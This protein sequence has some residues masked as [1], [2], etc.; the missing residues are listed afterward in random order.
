MA[1]ILVLGAGLNGLMT[2]MLLA[3]DG[4]AVTV[5]ERDQAPPPDDPEA[6]WEAW[7]RRGVNQFRMLHLMLPRWRALMAAELPE[8]LDELE[9][10]GGLRVNLV[11]SRRDERTGGARDG[12]DIFETMTAR[13]PVIESAVA[14]VA[15][16]T[17]GVRLRRGVAVTGLVTGTPA[18]AGVPH[19]AGVLVA[20]GEAVRAH[21]VVDTCGRR[22]PLASWLEAA[23]ARRPVE[24]REDCGFVYY[25][26][27]F[28]S[29]RGELPEPL[30]SP[31]GHYDSLSVLTLP[32]DNGTWGVGLVTSGKDRDLRALRDPDVWSRVLARYPLYAHWADG[33]PLAAD[34]AVMA[35]I[36][37]R[38][39]RLV[40]DGQPVATGVVPVGDSWACTNPSLG[41]GTSIGMI[42]ALALRDLLREVR[43]DEPDKLARRF[44][45]VS[46]AEVEPLYRATLAVDRH[47]L[48]QIDAD[49]AG[50]P[51]EPDD[52]VFAVSRAMAA[53]AWT[54][55]DVLRGFAE[56][57]S[58][59]AMP[60]EVLARPGMFERVIEVGAG[61]PAYVRPGP[62]RHDLLRAVAA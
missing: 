34:V 6:A 35:G 57:A 25:G 60:D 27:H 55:P 44:D 51:Y 37:D 46:C 22:S 54:D 16:R 14:A 10:R 42:H 52:P 56:I 43:P 48:H 12:D 59:L 9:R 36:E 26:R 53:A 45:E 31:L 24:E 17:P 49:I 40:V 8:V 18:R 30:D 58:L 20:G 11:T 38:H 33:Q 13:R 4:H 62:D 19:V 32:A 7:Q 15:Q 3:R 5:L 23:G 2:A 61:L 21:L 47:R 39:R 50:R 1:G 29:P 28:R 41:R